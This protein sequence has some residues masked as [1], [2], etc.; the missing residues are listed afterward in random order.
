MKPS[1]WIEKRA[2]ERVGAETSP[3][4]LHAHI[5]AIID[6]LDEQAEA[7]ALESKEGG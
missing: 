3:N 2:N 4:R 1:E 5:R 6:Y 7:N